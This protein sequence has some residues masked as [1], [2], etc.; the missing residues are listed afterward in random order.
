[1]GSC[2]VNRN[3]TSS[4]PLPST[5]PHHL[6]SYSH[7]PRRML[8]PNRRRPTFL[9]VPPKRLPNPRPAHSNRL[10]GPPINLPMLPFNPLLYLLHLLR[11]LHPLALTLT[12]V[13]FTPLQT[14][15]TQHTTTTSLAG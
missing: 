3:P 4:I 5:L 1:M 10:S 8:H 15:A 12:S 2:V 13:R 14:L 7:T 6:I 9:I 11:Q